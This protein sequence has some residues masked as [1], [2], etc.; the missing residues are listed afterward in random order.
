M[1][2]P[3]LAACA[4]FSLATA[5]SSLVSQTVADVRTIPNSFQ[6]VL[7]PG[8]NLLPLSRTRGFIQTWYH[9]SNMKIFPV[10]ELG[11][12]VDSGSNAAALTHTLEVTLASTTKTFST[13][14]PTFANNLTNP[15]LFVAKRVINFPAVT[16]P[17]DPNAPSLWIKGDKPFVFT[18]PHLIVQFDIQT[19]TSYGAMPGTYYADAYSMGSAAIDTN[20][21]ASCGAATSRAPCSSSSRSRAERRRRATARSRLPRLAA[22]WG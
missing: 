1:T 15:T 21:G 13:L 16:N 12:R 11:V 19:S 8:A 2:S 17:T 3:R 10:L 9:G 18:G 20:K 7:A 22:P 6:G 4:A 5:A 14:D